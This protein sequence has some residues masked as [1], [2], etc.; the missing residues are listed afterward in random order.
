MTGGTAV[1]PVSIQPASARPE[2]TTS[3][4]LLWPALGT[5]LLVL[6]AGSALGYVAYSVESP[7][8]SPAGTC[9]LCLFAVVVLAVVGWLY[10]KQRNRTLGRFFVV[11][12]S[13]VGLLVIWWAWAFAMPA[14]MAWDTTATPNALTALRN[15]APQHSVCKEVTRGSVGPLTA[16]Y[17]RCAVVGPPGAQVEYLA[18]DSRNSPVRGLLYFD[19]SRLVGSG[20]FVRHLVGNWYAFTQDASG[21]LGYSFTGGA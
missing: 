7:G 4:R 12:M 14:A 6:F 3:T 10:Y 9:A 13:A 1:T 17:E 19:G 11:A 5:A 21:A 18:G 8:I 20:Q 16:P 2:E 15:L